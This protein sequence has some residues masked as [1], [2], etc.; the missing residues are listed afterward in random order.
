MK[1][2]VKVDKTKT[3]DAPSKKPKEVLDNLDGI[4]EVIIVD[5]PVYDLFDI[6]Y[7]EAVLEEAAIL[8]A[9][10]DEGYYDVVLTDCGC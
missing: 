3:K 1:K 7:D 2:Q 10:D 9:L 4:T 8:A 6:A 5:D